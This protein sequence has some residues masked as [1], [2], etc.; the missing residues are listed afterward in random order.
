MHDLIFKRK[1]IFHIL[2]GPY[3]YHMHILLFFI[4]YPSV[5]DRYD[6]LLF[7]GVCPILHFE[8]MLKIMDPKNATR[9][10][11]LFVKAV[12]YKYTVSLE[13]VGYPL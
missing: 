1:H 11:F 12:S 3:A 9:V 4:S 6:I 7:F 5:P 2:Y 13:V 10:L 8:N